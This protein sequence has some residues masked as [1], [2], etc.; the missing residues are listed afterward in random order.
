MVTD[1]L[2]DVTNVLCV[3]KADRQPHQFGN[4]VGNQG[5]AYPCIHVQADPT[6]N[7]TDSRLGN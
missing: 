6:L 3:E 1:P 5:N 7:E 2:H 4:E